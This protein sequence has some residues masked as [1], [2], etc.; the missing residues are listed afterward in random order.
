LF[1]FCVGGHATTSQTLTWT[2]TPGHYDARGASSASDVEYESKL[3]Q[4]RTFML[5]SQ[6]YS[7]L[8]M[9]PTSATSASALA[10]P[11]TAPSPV[12]QLILLEDLPFVGYAELHQEFNSILW[13]AI[14]SSTYGNT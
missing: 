6:R 13:Q 1:C 2:D 11:L 8:A 7:A 14:H 12:K 3:T 9:K 10:L 5:R 4:F